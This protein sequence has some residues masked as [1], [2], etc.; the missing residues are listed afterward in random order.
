MPS[1]PVVIAAVFTSYFTTPASSID[2]VVSVPFLKFSP[3]AKDT[4]FGVPSFAL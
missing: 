3:S 1:A 2:A 4:C